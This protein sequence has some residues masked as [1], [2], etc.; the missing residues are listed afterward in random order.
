MSDIE[1]TVHDSVMTCDSKLQ[2][3]VYLLQNCNVGLSPSMDQLSGIGE[4]VN[5]VSID[6]KKAIDILDPPKKTLQIP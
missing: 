6:L 4:L 3:L 2:G 5:S 1:K